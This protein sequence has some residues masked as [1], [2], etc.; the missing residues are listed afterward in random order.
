MD[1]NVIQADVTKLDMPALIVNLFDGVK[2]P[3]GATRAIDSALDGA[4]TRLI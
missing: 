4:I 3:G 1:I 2:Q